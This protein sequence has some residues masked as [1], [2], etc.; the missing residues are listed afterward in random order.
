MTALGSRN[1]ARNEKRV[2]R[3]AQLVTMDSPWLSWTPRNR[4]ETIMKKSICFSGLII[5]AVAPSAFAS[6]VG[7]ASFQTCTDASGNSY[8]VQRFG[9][10]TYMTGHSDNGSSWSQ[11]SN[12]IGN[13]TYHNG[14]AA[15]GNS[16]SGTTTRIG[17]TT[18]HSGTDSDGNS[19]S[20]SCNQ[21]GCN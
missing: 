19:Y 6:C 8:N 9:N 17:S 3:M 16:W 1:R 7:S 20:S 10:S 18:F 14:T 13:T 2:D 4:M 5:A 15:D 12:T 21:Y 11:N